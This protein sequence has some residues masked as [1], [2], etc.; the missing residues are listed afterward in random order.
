MTRAIKNILWATDFSEESK[1]ALAY[2]DLFAKTTK[3]KLTALHVVP[4]FAPALYEMWPEAQ[5]EMAGKIEATK[6]SGKAQLDHM[7]TTQGVC[8]SHAVVTEGSRTRTSSSS[9]GR[10]SPGTNTISSAA[11]P[12]RSCAAPESRSS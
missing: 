5:A 12:T 6:I 9:A 10:A 11:S 4:D 7:C 8:P 3:A 2:A 1:E